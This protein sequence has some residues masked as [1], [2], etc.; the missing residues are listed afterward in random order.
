ME[1]GRCCFS[2]LLCQTR[3]GKARYLLW[4]FPPVSNGNGF[5]VL[6]YLVLC[7]FS[8]CLDY[9]SHGENGPRSSHSTCPLPSKASKT[10]F[11]HFCLTE[12]GSRGIEEATPQPLLAGAPPLSSPPTPCP[13]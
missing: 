5:I 3:M 4:A 1:V 9:K 7:L 12:L 13:S 8:H 2:L 10:H 11:P 6:E